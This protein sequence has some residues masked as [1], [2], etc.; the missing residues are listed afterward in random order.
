VPNSPNARRGCGRELK[1]HQRG[2]WCQYR[3]GSHPIRY[4]GTRLFLRGRESAVGAREADG[5]LHLRLGVLLTSSLD[6]HDGPVAR[7]GDLTTAGCDCP[8]AGFVGRQELDVSGNEG[9]E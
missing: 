3:P 9:A 4:G 5:R 6:A 7:R 1:W 8:S 2:F